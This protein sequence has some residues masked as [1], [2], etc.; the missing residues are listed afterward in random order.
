MTQEQ[1][2]KEVLDL[3]ARGKI[4]IDEAVTLLEQDTEVGAKEKVGVAEDVVYKLDVEDEPVPGA[5][6]A[7]K[8]E[9]LPAATARTKNDQPR[10]LRIRVTELSSGKSKVIVNIPFGMVKF[11][12]GMAKMFA[13]EKF[14][15]DW[16]QIGEML[17]TGG[18]GL[19][20]DVEDAESNE[21]VQIYVD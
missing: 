18:E 2:R 21:H 14:G 1:T 7:L 15:A 9:E 16:D 5:K 17:P 10:W 4:G 20:V 6:Q 11:G 3:L 12:L 13:P 8:V 19:M